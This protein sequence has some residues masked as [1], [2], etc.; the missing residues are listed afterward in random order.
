MTRTPP[1]RLLL[2]HYPYV[3]PVIARYADVDPLWHINNV[4]I[5]QYFE[6]TRISL[7]RTILGLQRIAFPSGRIV[8]AHQ[9]IDY[10][11]EGTYPGSLE[12]GAALARAGRTSATVVMGL[13]QSDAC[14]A[15]SD[16]VL[17]RV[18]AKGPCAWTADE[19][20]VIADPVWSLQE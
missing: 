19:R 4:A 3:S 2:R 8:I 5:A 12:V 9:S 18:D 14:I 13:F 1:N 17:V 20:K 7:L 16:A 10:L 6:D 15:V 11:L